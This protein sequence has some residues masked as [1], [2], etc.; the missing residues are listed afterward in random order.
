MKQG[1]ETSDF[2]FP[3]EQKQKKSKNA[4]PGITPNLHDTK[5]RE[6]KSGPQGYTIHHIQNGRPII[7]GT[8]ARIATRREGTPGATAKQTGPYL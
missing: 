2:S 1:E 5:D 6:R 8:G 7:R 4:S 3:Q